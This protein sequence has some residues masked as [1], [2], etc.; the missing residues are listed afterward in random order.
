MYTDIKHK[1]AGF[2]GA[3]AFTVA[4]AGGARPARAGVIHGDNR[5]FSAQADFTA[6]LADLATVS[7]TVS[8]LATAVAS[9]ATAADITNTE[10][11]PFAADAQRITH[12]GAH[13]SC[14][15]SIP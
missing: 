9:G 14:C 1:F 2:V 15:S 11:V 13:R 6:A 10:G 5:E 7:V 3:A 12:Q 8:L 4:T